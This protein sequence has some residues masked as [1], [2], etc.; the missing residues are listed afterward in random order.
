MNGEIV[1]IQTASEEAS[2]LH[3]IGTNMFAQ[4]P[5][6]VTNLH[7]KEWED[8]NTVGNSPTALS[9]TTPT[10]I[11]FEI[12]PT[13]HF[14]KY[15]ELRLSLTASG[16]TTNVTFING[17]GFILLQDAEERYVNKTISQRNIPAEYHYLK[18]MTCQDEG[19][20]DSLAHNYLYFPAGQTDAHRNALVNGHQFI[21]DMDFGNSRL[22]RDTLYLLSA[23]GQVLRREIEIV[24]LRHLIMSNIDSS[25]P[26][27][28]TSVDMTINEA[29]MR[30]HVI[31]V[32]DE[33]AHAEL[34]RIES[35]RGLFDMVDRIEVQTGTIPATTVV[36]N[37]ELTNLRDTYKYLACFF[38]PAFADREVTDLTKG[39][40]PVGFDN[41]R[42]SYEGMAN[43]G[44][45]QYRT[46]SVGA[47]SNSATLLKTL[48]N[49]EYGYW[50]TAV[51]NYKLYPDTATGRPAT[52]FG[53]PWTLQLLT[54]S[55]VD[56]MKQ[57]RVHDLCTRGYAEFCLKHGGV[58]HALPLKRTHAFPIPIIHFGEMPFKN[59]N[60]LTGVK[61]FS[62]HSTVTLR[63]DFRSS[64]DGLPAT[65]AYQSNSGSVVWNYMI[66]GVGPNWRNRA[67]GK[68]NL[69]KH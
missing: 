13:S 62:V 58:E 9:R 8:Y 39:A 45:V 24:P 19:T 20:A 59:P 68:M 28:L 53:F 41:G 27:T 11:A 47:G 25:T 52:V 3:T 61:D 1:G 54:T 44:A 22:R 31:H 50:N 37:I 66:M 4:K 29:I 6:S 34:Q 21:L 30:V 36:Q 10:R 23:L 26:S 18:F 46:G 7:H 16:T 57:T 55:G 60:C 14:E 35:P 12:S 69:V 51:G 2:A 56:I 64:S 43:T 65:S 49:F 5:F 15:A 63:V 17:A 42:I 32:L 38:W 48:G 67:E 40:I 33:Q